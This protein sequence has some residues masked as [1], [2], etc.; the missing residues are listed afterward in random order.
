ME[1]YRGGPQSA[2]IQKRTS[3]LKFDD[4]AEKSVEK[5]LKYL[6]IPSVES[7]LGRFYW[8]KRERWIGWTG[9]TGG[10]TQFQVEKFPGENRVFKI[11]W[12]YVEKVC[13]CWKKYIWRKLYIYIY[14]YWKICWKKYAGKKYIEKYIFQCNQNFFSILA[15]SKIPLKLFTF[16][17]ESLRKKA[18]KVIF[19]L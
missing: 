16:F 13:C 17:S 8:G 1:T 2:S 6:P 15:I 10:A 5:M 4:S 11:F 3:P 19:S 12:K 14:I 7:S 18:Y 9:A